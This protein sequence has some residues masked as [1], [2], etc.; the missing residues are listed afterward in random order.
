MSL[1]VALFLIGFISMNVETDDEYFLVLTLNHSSK[2]IGLHE[3]WIQ[4]VTGLMKNIQP[5]PGL[6]RD[7][8]LTGRIL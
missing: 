6:N 2:S 3:F 7:P 5:D 8:S 4:N 1:V